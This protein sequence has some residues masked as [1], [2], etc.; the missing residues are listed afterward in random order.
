MEDRKAKSGSS[1]NLVVSFLLLMESNSV[2]RSAS[3]R[4]LLTKKQV[5]RLSPEVSIREVKKRILD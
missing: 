2:F 1:S 5:S 4:L 3:P